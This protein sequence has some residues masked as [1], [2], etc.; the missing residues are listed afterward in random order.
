MKKLLLFLLL[1][2]FSIDTFAHGVQVAY[3]IRNDGTIRIWIE[4]WHGHVSNVNSYPLIVETYSNGTL[5][6]NQTYYA[7]GYQ[8]STSLG[9]LPNQ[10][11]LNVLSACPNEANY[12]NNWVYWDFYPPVCNQTIDLVIVDGPSYTTEEACSSLYPQ[13][14]TSSFMDVYPPTAVCATYDAYLDAN[15]SVSVTASDI[16]GGST[17]NCNLTGVSTPSTTYTCTDIGTQTMVLT[18]TD[19]QGLTNT[20]NATVNVI[21]TIS[22]VLNVTASHTLNLGAT[23]VVNLTTAQVNNGSTDNCAISSMALSRDN[24]NCADIG[25]T[26][27]LF[28]ATDA[29]GNMKTT[30]I[31]VTIADNLGPVAVYQPASVVLDASG[32]ASIS[33]SDINNGSYDNCAIDSMYLSQTSFDCSDLG[34]NTIQFTLVDVNGNTTQQSVVVTVSDNAAPVVASNNATVYL[35]ANGQATISSS[36]VV[37][38]SSDNCS[39]SSLVLSN[40]NFNCSNLG[41]N[42]VTITAADAA[43]N[44]STASAVVTVMDTTSPTVVFQNITLALDASGSALLSPNMINSGTTDNCGVASS[45][46]S[47]TAFDCSHLGPNNV[48]LT[49]T[50]GAGNSSSQSGI[51]TIIDTLAPTVGY[52]HFNA[53]VDASGSY[54]FNVNMAMGTSSDNCGIAT[55]SAA[56]SNF[57]CSNIGLNTV[58][59]TSTDGSGNS[60][61]AIANFTLLDTVSPV[62]NTNAFTAYIGPSGTAM[63]SASDVDNGT[64]DNCQLASLLLGQTVF[65]CADIGTNSVSVVAQDMYGNTTNGTVDITILDTIAPE[66]TCPTFVRACPDSILWDEP[67]VMDN[68]NVTTAITSGHSNGDYFS[69]GNY[70]I[71]YEAT[72]AAGNSA[73]CHF[74][75]EVHPEPQISLGADTVVGQYAQFSLGQNFDPSYTYQW[76]TGATTFSESVVAE[77]DHVVWVTAT[78]GYGCSASDSVNISVLLGVNEQLASALDYQVYPNPVSNHLKIEWESEKSTVDRIQIVD[79]EG[80]L[81]HQIEPYQLMQMSN[82]YVPTHEWS[83]GMYHVRLLSNQQVLTYTVVKM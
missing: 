83:K 10:G 57:D 46:I 59:L 19:A 37:A 18:A 40:S 52:Q 30:P 22:P 64:S 23:G 9:N 14:I 79:M 53:Y 48:T 38:T 72:D 82:V 32:N 44:T 45:V 25:T 51:V 26:T 33:V 6:A 49:V 12:Y 67:L 4:H 16:D 43:G 74:N 65:T 7:N 58:M 21:D 80:R 73:S 71:Q 39:V 3:E 76:S 36:N 62:I 34:S 75:L 56:Q 54:T 78:N 5:L 31:T 63:V 2:V 60:A 50:D 1:S 29:S 42:N 13:T 77:N 28:S 55:L 27:V 69:T 20:C 35:N 11:T 15:G 41:A 8:N 24:F 70:V 68:C 47:Q 66:I 17:D 61:S 81:V